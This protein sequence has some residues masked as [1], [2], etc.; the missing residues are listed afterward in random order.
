MI[1]SF[2]KSNAQ[3]AAEAEASIP[4]SARQAMLDAR[5]RRASYEDERVMDEIDHMTLAFTRSPDEARAHQFALDLIRR[6]GPA[7]ARRIADQMVRYVAFL[8][9]EP[10]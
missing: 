3:R 7:E 9:R 8:S 5:V 4:A 6:R 2:F 10:R 1:F